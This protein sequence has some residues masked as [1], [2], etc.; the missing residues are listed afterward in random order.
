M[1]L[2]RTGRQPVLG[3]R[4]VVAAPHHAASQAGLRMLQRGG[5]AVDAAIA[6]NAVLAVVYP[7]MAGLGGDLFCLLWDAKAQRLDG[8]NASGRAAR[9]A[10]VD[11]YRERGHQ[12]IPIRGPLAAL[13]APGCV[14][15][16]W[17]LHQ[18]LGQL[19]FGELLEPAI[20]LAEGGFPVPQ[21]LAAWTVTAAE[22]LQKD[23]TTARTFRPS[24]RP[25]RMGEAFATPALART[26]RHVADGGPDA[27]YRGPVAELACAYLGERGGPLCPDDFAAYRSNW[28]EPISASYRGHTVYQLPPNTQG[29]A[30]L[31]ILSLLEAFDLPT[32]GDLSTEYV[33]LLA[34]TAR[35]AFE[36]RDRYLT[37]PDFEEIPIQRL[38]SPEHIASIRARIDLERRS[39]RR[40]AAAVGGDTCYLCAVDREG[41]AVS[42]I[43]SVY[44][45]FGSAV[46]AGESGLVMQN[47]GSFFSLDPE[48]PNRLVP[49]KRTFHTLIPA[50]LFK[51]GQPSLV[52]GAM[53]GE[54]QPQTQAMVATRVLDF[55]YDVQRAV[56]APRWLYGR[57][58]GA[59][60][61]ALTLEESIGPDVAA[62][63]SSMGHDVRTVPAWSDTMG[64]AQAIQI[65]RDHG[66]LWGAADPRSDGAAAGW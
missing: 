42:L 21:S 65:D 60:S 31:Q 58:W 52:Y 34:E 36:D 47:R 30:A 48:H 9:A 39:D 2:S 41:N 10:N 54:G 4:G 1:T 24:G 22:I 38:L 18:R 44:Y 7:H 64:H 17:Q 37:D 63:L 46:V 51:D 55:G 32:F 13:T 40:E 45:D 53:G 29:L 62:R 16:W 56:E 43:Q 3:A 61:V 57:T 11:F 66:T 5:S 14:D 49:G 27:F 25:L 6:A 19:P 26:L 12:A 33:H 8:L 50:M 15:G 20:E 28:V 59:Q 23:Q 35:L